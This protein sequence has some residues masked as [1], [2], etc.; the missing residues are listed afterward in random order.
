MFEAT[1]GFQMD[2]RCAPLPVLVLR[3][4]GTFC[5]PQK[6]LLGLADTAIYARKLEEK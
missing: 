5:A 2:V 3:S 6:E 1:D 4:T